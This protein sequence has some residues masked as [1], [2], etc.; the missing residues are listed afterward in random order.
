MELKL[1]P[2]VSYALALEGGGARGAYQIG[3]WRALRQAGIRIAAAAG[4]SVG[5][6]NGGVIA[7]GDYD[8]AAELWEN[9][10]YS[11]VIEADDDVMHSLMS[12][13][14][15]L[16]NIKELLGHVG[17]VIK[18]RGF[19]VTPLRNMLRKYVP[20]DAVRASDVEL[21]IVTTSLSDGGEELELRARDLGDGELADMLMASAYLPVFKA[22][23]LGGK[24]YA[25]GGFRDVLPL[26]VLIENGYKNIIAIRLYGTGIERAV[27]IPRDTQ[28]ITVEPSDELGGTLEFEAENARRN[29]RLGYFDT[30]R[31]LYGLRGKK[32]FI[33]IDCQE[34]D[35][36]ALLARS[37]LRVGAENGWSLRAVHEKLLPEL[38][39]RAD[40][41]KGD[42][43]DILAA[44]LEEA[45]DHIGLDRWKIYAETELLSAVAAR[46]PSTGSWA[47]WRRR[48]ERPRRRNRRCPGP[49]RRGGSWP[50]R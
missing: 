12:G 34:D 46:G 48:C 13:E 19:D 20:E 44:A 7:V 10:S 16:S 42:Y 36:R 1:D 3:A 33:D 4:T 35:A 41:E 25:D 30:M 47:P 14:I 40:A 24:R 45:A 5:A 11:Q 27:R 43:R 50:N 18:N 15:S 17:Q 39:E 31:L 6:L 26:H 49:G 2:N 9:I 29:M 22:E 21:F 37:A 8:L 32:Y 28:V 38:A 23:K